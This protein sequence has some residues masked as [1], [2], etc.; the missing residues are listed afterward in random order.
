MASWN[1]FSRSPGPSA[2]P[3]RSLHPEA[4]PDEQDWRVP[5]FFRQGRHLGK[6]EGEPVQRECWRMKERMKTVSVA[7]V[8]CLNIDV[9]PPDVLKTS[10]CARMETWIDPRT[11]TRA[12]RAMDLIA[13]N[14]QAQYQRWQPKARY[15]HSL[16]PTTDDVKKLCTSLR[17]N[18]KEE[19]ILFHYNGHGV[20]RP[21]SNGEIW[22]FNRNYSQYIPLSIYELQTWMGAPSIYVYDCSSAGQ[23][24]DSF[25]LFASQRQAENH[26]A[27][28]GGTA[29]L[30]SC[31]QLAACGAKEILP[32]HPDLPA[33]LFT[34]CLTTPIR[35]ALRWFVIGRQSQL[36]T[37]VTVDDLDKIPGQLTDRRTMLGELN[38]IFTAI[39]DTIAWNTLPRDVFQRLFRQDLLVASLFRNFLLAERIMKSYD[40]TPVSH[41]FLPSTHKHGMWASWDLAVDVCLL[42][43]PA[44]IRE[45]RQTYNHSTFFEEELTAFQVW[46]RFGVDVKQPPEQLPIV[47]Q[48]LLSQVHRV[49]ALDLLSRFLD[50]GSW[51]VNQALSVG[52]F[53]YVLK[54]LQASARELRPLLVIIWAKIMALDP[55]CQVD[56]VRD[57]G[58]RY[59]LDVLADPH[60][61]AEHRTMA[62]FVLATMVRDY[63]AGQ[64]VAL[65][66]SLIPYCVE[67]M[68]D[69]SPLLRSWLA[70]TLGHLW[71]HNDQARWSG[72]RDMAHDKLLALLEDE[73]PEVRTAAV[74]ALGTFMNAVVERTE[75]ANT[76]DHSVM[77]A[78]LK[79]SVGD[80]SPMVRRELISTFSSFVQQFESKFVSLAVQE[81]EQA[82]AL[83]EQSYLT[84][85]GASGSSRSPQPFKRVNSASSLSGINSP[86]SKQRT[87]VSTHMSLSFGSVYWKVWHALL[88]LSADPDYQVADMVRK[89][90][91]QIILKAG[92]Q[93]KLSS[94]THDVGGISPQR[95]PSEP[96]S[97]GWSPLHR[98]ASR[99]SADTARSEN[100]RREIPLKTRFIE[101]MDR[102]Y[103]RPLNLFTE[104][105]DSAEDDDETYNKECRFVENARVR[106]EGERDC[107]RLH[108]DK[109]D[110]QLS[111]LK[112]GVPPALMKFSPYTTQ[113]VVADKNRFCVVDYTK[114]QSITQHVNHLPSRCSQTRIS[115]LEF[116]NPHYQTLLLVAADDGSVR[117]WSDYAEPGLRTPH[118]VT[119]WSVL[120]SGI[121]PSSAGSSRSQSLV[122]TWVQSSG[123]L[124]A[125]EHKQLHVWDLQSERRLAEL[126]VGTDSTVTTLASNDNEPHLAVAGCAS[127]VVALFDTRLSGQASRVGLWRE[128]QSFVVTSELRTVGG[129][130]TAVTG[131]QKGEVRLWDARRPTSVRSFATLSD[132]VMTMAVHPTADLLACGSAHQHISLFTLTGEALNSIRYHDGFMGHRIGPVSYLAFHPVRVALA[133]GSSDSL[134]SVYG[135]SRS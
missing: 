73:V 97:P 60:M 70:I 101:W 75:H 116:I 74:Y 124:V 95:S 13:A 103:A 20:P 81:D 22:V 1:T 36:V 114:G 58:H 55:A 25:N 115:G 56:L 5:A 92:N 93:G 24:V 88:E 128:H 4:A 32:Q 76:V 65:Q 45:N 2:R 48:V 26:A 96:R 98:P 63:R 83:R 35:M 28:E 90:T 18:A 3:R 10:P 78:L 31:I 54:L 66:G 104:Y 127:G 99:S 85:T 23:I 61:P 135:L 111:V 122:V 47:L 62:A 87:S 9:D 126:A 71:L 19:R 105:N 50:L 82:A 42:Q 109:L 40:C 33:D 123:R 17:R 118:C 59:F 91:Q 64:Q 112:H 129:N 89:L 14:L 12:P 107:G 84:V 94:S 68:D 15:K 80:G 113:L 57:N 102:F 131:D 119:S 46:L 134:V 43:L 133:A 110:T 37:G 125:G 16:D 49:R 11:T 27:S 8:L 41:P 7:L 30:S 132:D 72:V 21:T 51:A 69:P 79:H 106:A 117:V 53:P 44:I 39:T 121:K 34:C 77:M 108:Q 6:I 100:T 38:W 86:N 52:I 130:T 67:Q 29:S 120:D